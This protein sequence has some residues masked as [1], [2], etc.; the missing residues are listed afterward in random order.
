[1]NIT[2]GLNGICHYFMAVDYGVFGD[3]K[4]IKAGL[5]QFLRELRESKKAKGQDRVYTHGERKMETM[6]ARVNG[7]IPVN[8]KTLAEMQAIAIRQGIPWNLQ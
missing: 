2:P 4:T 1:V 7:T 5:S 8:V 3:K 6:A